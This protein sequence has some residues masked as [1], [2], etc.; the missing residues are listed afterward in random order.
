MANKLAHAIYTNKPLIF[1]KLKYIL[2]HWCYMTKN[3]FKEIAK[4]F[5][6]FE[7]FHALFHGSLAV[8]G[9]SLTLLGFTIS[10][11][12]SLCAAAFHVAFSA[13]LAWYGWKKQN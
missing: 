9:T 11:T 13:F 12:G 2:R 10:P 8:T 4:F 1:M 7:A 6:G 5:S 3:R